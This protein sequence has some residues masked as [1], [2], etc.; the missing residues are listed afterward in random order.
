M[1]YNERKREVLR[2]VLGSGPCGVADVAAGLGIPDDHARP[3]LRSYF[4]QGLLD[5][6][7][8][9]MK[10]GIYSLNSKGEARLR[11]LEGQS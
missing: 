5:R 10:S 1:N 9:P 11:W 4:K 8:G 2:Y 7:V 3:L 6:T